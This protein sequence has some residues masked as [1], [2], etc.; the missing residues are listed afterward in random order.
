[1]FLRSIIISIKHG[2]ISYICIYRFFCQKHKNYVKNIFLIENRNFGWKLIYWSKIE[3]LEKHRFFGEKSKFWRKIEF[4][5]KNRNFGEKSKCIVENQFFFRKSIFFGNQ[6][7]VENRNFGRKPIFWSKLDI[8]FDRIINFKIRKFSLKPKE[9]KNL[10]NFIAVRKRWLSWENV[11][12]E[13]YPDAR[14]NN[15]SEISYKSLIDIIKGA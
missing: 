3:I 7:L 14:V 12:P 9:T 4:L 13:N 15:M 10:R 6:F 8:Q 1:M 5:E 11:F 2:F